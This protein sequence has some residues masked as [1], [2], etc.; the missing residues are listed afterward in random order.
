MRR[1]QFYI[2][3]I[4]LIAVAACKDGKKGQI[5]GTWKGAKL[6]NAEMDS[7]YASTKKMIDTMGANKDPRVNFE[8]YNTT[9]IDSLKKSM[10]KEADSL[11]QQEI[12]G[13]LTTTFT[14]DKSGIA[15]INFFGGR[16]LDTSKW[17]VENEEL[18]MTEMIGPEKGEVRRLRII[19]LDDKELKL[20]F[21]GSLA[22]SE[23]TFT[24]Q[25]K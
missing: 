25:S 15:Y 11:H 22:F 3:F 19:K 18:V 21:D 14:F 10:L 16:S 5:I 8:L 6:E 9:N 12:N 4:G 1:V 7:F 20:K 23:V 24:K 13:V 17:S 2:F